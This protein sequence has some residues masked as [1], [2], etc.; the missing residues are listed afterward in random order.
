[1][2]TSRE[3][4]LIYVFAAFQGLSNGALNAAMPTFVG[5]YFPRNRYS[6]VMGVVLPFQVCSNAVAATLAGIIFDAT[7]TYT[8]AFMT[9][10]IF[11]TAGLMFAFLARKPRQA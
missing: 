5:S 1:M 11:S 10:A 7:S 3:L 8:P 6:Q 2:L 4:G 9:A